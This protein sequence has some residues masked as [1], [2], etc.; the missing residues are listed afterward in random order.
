MQNS[1]GGSRTFFSSKSIMRK[2]FEKM[3]V[4]EPSNVQLNTVRPRFGGRLAM[5]MCKLLNNHG[6]DRWDLV[7]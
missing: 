4:G 2:R 1:L 5:H 3:V 7:M 6:G